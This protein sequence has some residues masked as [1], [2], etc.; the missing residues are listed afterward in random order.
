VQGPRPRDAAPAGGLF[1]V[2]RPRPAAR[3]RPPPS[4]R[5]GAGEDPPP[6]RGGTRGPRGGARRVYWRF[7]RAAGAGYPLIRLVPAVSRRKTK[8]L[9]RR[10]AANHQYS[11]RAFWPGP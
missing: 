7:A 4:R 3:D 6:A 11:E 9:S 8:A 5:P 2:R 1:Y 10:A